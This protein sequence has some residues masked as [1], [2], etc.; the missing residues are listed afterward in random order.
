MLERSN[1]QPHVISFTALR[2]VIG[3]FATRA[4][5]IVCP[6][7]V[8]FALPY[9]IGDV[10]SL[11][12]PLRWMRLVL[13]T[14]ANEVPVLVIDLSVIITWGW[15]ISQGSFVNSFN[16]LFDFMLLTAI[17]SPIIALFMLSAQRSVLTP[18]ILCLFS[19]FAACSITWIILS[20]P[21]HESASLLHSYTRKFPP[22]SVLPFLDRK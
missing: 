10:V 2:V 5:P 13:V 15:F 12:V 17:V 22:S 21:V 6:G 14:S 8:F 3:S 20:S 19:I 1:F 16:A 18:T 9:K 7:G 11:F 4:E